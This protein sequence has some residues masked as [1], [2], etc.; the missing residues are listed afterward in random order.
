MG[1]LTVLTIVTFCR[2]P[3]RRRQQPG[4]A[5]ATPVLDGVVVGQRNLE[6]AEHETAH[7][8]RARGA[9][10]E[11]VPMLLSGEPAVGVCVDTQCN[12]E[13]TPMSSRSQEDSQEDS[14]ES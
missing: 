14:Q 13:R 8:T 6:E 1:F 5:M 10:E 2:V 7:L 4:I 9:V 12:D 3:N 11:S